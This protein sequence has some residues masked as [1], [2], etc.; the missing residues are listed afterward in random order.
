MV[1]KQMLRIVTPRLGSGDTVAVV[2]STATLGNWN[3]EAATRMVC[4]A[5]PVWSICVDLTPDT[6]YKF[7][8]VHADGS[9]RWEDGDNRTAA[10]PGPLYF[11]GLPQWRGVGTAIP[12]FSLRS[13]EDCGIG[14][15]LDLRQLIDWA[16]A[17][18]QSVV[19]ILP[20]NDTTTSRTNS[21]SYPYSAISSFALHPIYLRVTEVGTLTDADA[22]RRFRAEAARLNASP[23]VK[24][25]E[26]LALKEQ[27]VNSLFE[28]QA[29]STLHSVE[30]ARFMVRSYRWLLPYAAF[31]VLRD[32]FHTA[33]HSQ[34]PPE[35]ARFTNDKIAD[36]LVESKR[37]MDRVCFVQYHLDRQLRSVCDYARSR[38]VAVKGDIPIGVSHDSADAWQYP[39]LFNLDSCAGAP[40]D[41]FAKTGQNW[42]F[43]TYNWDRMADDN[44]GWWRMRFSQM[45]E[46]FSA[47][48]IDH[49]LGFFRIWEIP[50]RAVNGLLGHFSPALPLAPEEMHRLYGFQFC[51]AEQAKDITVTTDT[52]FVADPRDPGKFHPRI[53][54]TETELFA[55]LNSEQQAAYRRLY[56]DFFYHR[57]D[58]MWAESAMRKLPTLTE[59]TSML[60]CAEDLG[61]IPACVPTVLHRLQILALEVQRMSKI[62]GQP[63]GIPSTYSWLSVAT[64]STHDMP[65][66]RNWLAD[67]EPYLQHAFANAYGY[68]NT[69]AADLPAELCARV[70]ADHLASP[71]ML[72]IFPLQDWL[73]TDARLRRP[74]PADEQINDPS[75]PNNFWCYRM[76]LTLEELN[77]AETFNNRVSQMIAD[78]NRK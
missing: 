46:Y 49:V 6:E 52:L 31:C 54:G 27:Y 38:G 34:W 29:D 58:L 13:A 44:Y 72:A 22:M 40:P 59:S 69:A 77:A 7:V 41:A 63:L 37:E 45:A 70:I 25:E 18:G 28:Q 53:E 67:A 73:A 61:M 19:Q 48:R 62:Y 47:Y 75:N 65:G 17:T 10:E 3:P 64:T 8:V 15:F 66:L 78:N 36:L 76:H 68:G 56:E 14:D 23:T 5:M 30:F 60:P 1:T 42:G 39:D 50:A 55:A 16:A 11:R 24:Y 57:H 51:E 32:R 9:V 26:V 71:A 35:F 33:D 12:V 21:D 4:G 20:I 43:P 2:G 74:N